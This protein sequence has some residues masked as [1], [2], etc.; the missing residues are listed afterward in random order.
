MLLAAFVLVRTLRDIPVV[1]EAPPDDPD[2][3]LPVR[4]RNAAYKLGAA[5]F[6]LALVWFTLD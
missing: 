1:G 3:T 4:V 2:Q 6:M 5:A